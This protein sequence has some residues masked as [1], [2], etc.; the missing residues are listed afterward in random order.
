MGTSNKPPKLLKKEDCPSWGDKFET[1]VQA[2]NY[3]TW[4]LLKIK[5]IIQKNENGTNY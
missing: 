3:D 1:Y 4:M 5:Y 2:M